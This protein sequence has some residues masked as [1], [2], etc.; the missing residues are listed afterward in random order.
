MK[1][2]KNENELILNLK[3]VHLEMSFV[4]PKYVFDNGWSF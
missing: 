3:H 4:M 1:K 2:N